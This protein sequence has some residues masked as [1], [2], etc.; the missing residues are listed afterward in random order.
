M[1]LF[2]I[3]TWAN[4]CVIRNKVMENLLGLVVIY[5]KVIIWMMR[6]RGLELCILQMVPHIKVIGKKVCNLEKVP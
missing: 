6:G 4:M 5:I 3:N 1:L 2:V